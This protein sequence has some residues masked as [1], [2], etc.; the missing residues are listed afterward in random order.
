MFMLKFVAIVFVTEW[1]ELKAINAGV[2]T[3]LKII[4]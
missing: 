1:L 2:G 4:T 3:R